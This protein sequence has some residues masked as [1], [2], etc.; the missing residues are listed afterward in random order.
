MRKVPPGTQS[1]FFGRGTAAAVRPP[2]GTCRAAG[3]DVS[4]TG[5]SLAIIATAS[6]SRSTYGLSAHVDEHAPDRPAGEAPR[7]RSRVVVGD[8]LAAV[9][10]D[11]QPLAAD[12]ELARLGL[13]PA[14]ADLAVAVVERQD[15]VRDAGRVLAVLVEGRGQDHLVA[16]WNH[17]G[18]DDLLLDA[19]DEVVDVVQQAVLDVQRVAAEPGA[20]REQHPL[21]PLVRD[22]AQGADRVGPVADVD[23]LRLG[24]LGG[25]RVV[26]V[27]VAR[28]GEHRPRRGE[29]LHRAPV[30]ERERVVRARLHVPQVDQVAEPARLLGG[31]VVALRAVGRPCCT[32][33][34]CRWRSRPSS[35]R[36]RGWSRPS[37]RRARCC[38]TP[39]IE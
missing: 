24:H 39:S 31:Q 29:D 28:R 27:A 22:V 37:S 32:A 3:A 16:G 2:R 5:Y 18:G 10:A 34:R 33:P 30:V 38:A 14:L 25:T 19:A 9:T 12:G 21:R 20:V 15:A 4:A 13:D 6:R 23:R 36:R 1:M 7:R 11:A 17:L 26:G 8:R 35:A